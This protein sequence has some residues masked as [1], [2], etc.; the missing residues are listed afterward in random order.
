LKQPTTHKIHSPIVCCFPD[1]LKLESLS[2]VGGV[3]S[4]EITNAQ[5]AANVAI[6]NSGAI[7]TA[8]DQDV[9]TSTQS[10]LGEGVI[11]QEGEVICPGNIC[12]TECPAAEATAQGNGHGYTGEFQSYEVSHDA[13]PAVQGS[14]GEFKQL[15]VS[16]ETSESAMEANAE[17]QAV[18]A[19]GL[20][21]ASTIQNKAAVVENN[22]ANKEKVT[23]HI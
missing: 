19:A 5:E 20:T 16:H 22:A 8:S 2:Q 15:A 11:C 12:A 23:E 18:A 4:E 6:T 9:A 17:A 14:A 7:T 10:A 3:T 13:P 21:E 1:S